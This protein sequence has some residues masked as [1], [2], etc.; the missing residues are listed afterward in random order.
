MTKNF[1]FILKNIQIQN[2]NQ[3][4]RTEKLHEL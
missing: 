3:F 4:L 1:E 2:K